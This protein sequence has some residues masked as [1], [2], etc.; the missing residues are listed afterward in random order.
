MHTPL[1]GRRVVTT[2]DAPGRLDQRLRELGAEVVHVPLIEITDPPDG[3]ASLAALLAEIDRFD[4]VVVTSRHGAERVGAGLPAAIRTAAVGTAT[5]EALRHLTG[6]PVDLVPDVQR[7]T[8]LV[9]AFAA[10]R[11]HDRTWSILVAQADRAEPVLV[12][13]LRRAGHRVEVATA[14]ATRLRTPDPAQLAAALDADAVAFASGSAAEAWAT[15]IG[16]RTP[17]VV[18]A[19]GPTTARVAREHGLPVSAEASEHSVEGLVRCVVE[20]LAR[21]L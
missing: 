7:A 9:D 17:R 20:A 2:R 16:R 18:C 14:Y 15:A 5:A 8:A 19:I 10:R 1:T 4:W 13:G 3:G 6:R 11:D 21:V 12:D